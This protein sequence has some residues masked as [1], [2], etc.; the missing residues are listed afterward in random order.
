MVTPLCKPI[1]LS[2]LILQFLLIPGNICKEFDDCKL[3]T[4]VNKA[5]NNHQFDECWLKT[6]YEGLRL[7]AGVIS[8]DKG[9]PL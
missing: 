2:I 5:L 3:W 4:W 6:S 8:G 9:C 7:E 1:F